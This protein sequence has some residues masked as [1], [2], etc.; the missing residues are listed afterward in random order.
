MKT[1]KT[2]LKKA[3]CGKGGP[4]VDAAQG[5]ESGANYIGGALKNTIGNI[6]TG[7]RN[8]VNGI[9][10]AVKSGTNKVLDTAAN[11]V[12]KKVLQSGVQNS[13]KQKYQ[14]MQQKNG[15][16]PKGWDAETYRNFKKSNPN[17]E[18]TSEDTQ[19]MQNSK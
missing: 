1:K 18:P 15:L 11:F 17:L 3:C 7:V 9:G 6:G 14:N 12:D 5:I 10:S 19:R 16:L 2:I 8:T 13:N 4:L